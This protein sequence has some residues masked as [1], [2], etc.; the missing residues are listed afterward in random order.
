MYTPEGVA[1]L[2]T[3]L[4]L[5]KSLS[6]TDSYFLICNVFF[7]SKDTLFEVYFTALQLVLLPCSDRRT[8]LRTLP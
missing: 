4:L 3:S 1:V 7:V 8:S 2:L 6:K 5:M